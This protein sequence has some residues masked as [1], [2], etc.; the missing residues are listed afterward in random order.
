[1]KPLRLKMQAFGSYGKETTIDFEKVNQNLFLITGD[2]GAGKTTIFDAI[3]FALYGEASSSSNKKE[4]VVLQ[5]QYVSYEYEPF[6]ELVFSERSGEEQEIYTVRRVPRHLK[7]ITRGANKGKAKENTGSVS[8]IMPDGMEY[9]TKET[10]RKIQE[11]VGLT[12]SQFMQ[13]AMIAQGE[14]MDLL[15]AKSDDKKV[16]FRKLFNTEMYQDIVNELANRKRTKEK[17]IAVLRTQCQSNLGR[18]CI[19]EEYKSEKIKEL[20]EQLTDGEMSRLSDFLDELELLCNWFNEHT[21]AAENAYRKAGRDRDA[22]NE[23]YTR[24]EGLLKWF[25]QLDAAEQKLK[26]CEADKAKTEA[27]LSLISRIRDAYEIQGNYAL[28][29]DARKHLKDTKE[30]LENQ[31]KTLPALKE[32]REKAENTEKESKQIRDQEIQ[33]HSKTVEKVEK[34]LEIFGQINVLRMRVEADKKAND[35]AAKTTKKACETQEKLDQQETKWKAQSEELA[36]TEKK[37]VIAENKK[38]EADAV[39][40]EIQEVR[41]LGKQAERC[42]QIAIKTRD[43]YAKT[44]KDY[45]TAN[46][47]YEE[48]RRRF[49]NAQAGFLAEK[50]EPGKPCPVCGST[51]HPHPHQKSVDHVDISEEK[52]QIMQE[53][54]DKL[55]KKQEQKS[56]ESAAANSEYKTRKDTYVESVHKLQARLRR[57]IS[58]ITEETTV[59]EMSNAL[60]LWKQQT[61]AELE[62]LASEEKLLF[63]IRENLQKMDAQKKELQEK[64]EKCRKDEKAA[65]E[66]L[67]AS[68]AELK[69][70]KGSS[71]FQTKED[72]EEALRQSEKA[73]NHAEKI[74]A[75]ASK[76]A[77][78]TLNTQK[79]A[80]ALISRYQHELP[81]QK[82]LA[83]ERDSFYIKIMENKKMNE[84]AWKELVETYSRIAAEEFQ[85]TVT[86]YAQKKAAAEAGKTAAQNAIGEANRPVLEEIQKKK[87]AAEAAYLEAEKI[88]DRLRINNKDN[89]EVLDSLLSK[90]EERKTLLEE[91]ARI[92]ALYRMTS[93]NVSGARMDLETYVQRYYLERILYAANRRFQEM[94]AGQF[95]LRM[96]DLEKA[97]EGRNRGLDLMVYSTVTGKER[98]IRT[99]SGGESFMAA[100]SLA[101]GMADQIQQSSAAINLDMMFIDEGFGS[102]DE[103]SRNQAVRVLQEMAEGSRLIGIISHVSEL[104]QEIEDQLIVNKDENGSYVK[105]QIS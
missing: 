9:P 10:D 54:V 78:V 88:Y 25:E 103:H 89:R 7:P 11:I 87:E 14:F 61:E 94:S 75:K 105:W 31:E 71:E 40:Q 27:L 20:K 41:A 32:A 21:L 36:E 80:E 4:G 37:L 91:H 38:Q 72:A 84:E 49:L 101:L 53:N 55:R 34:A 50:L 57:S 77:E 1:M 69:N 83:D 99:L 90:L 96:C 51:E 8:L 58:S 48:L 22:K 39:S 65:A 28:L 19:P 56:G 100:L 82:R 47:E 6:V 85:Q 95:E 26:E 74:Y 63:Q 68:E 15:R 102:L 67:A 44:T 86:A 62:K 81:E 73:R 93:G 76:E 18:V 33:N 59:T 66:K 64:L 97:G 24:A 5:S 43:D 3:V 12:K 13:V 29:E 98:E 52:L 42:R 2:T 92:D 23:A 45:E 60:E 16:I 70:M 46:A 79:Q 35:A 104:K 17:D 30:A